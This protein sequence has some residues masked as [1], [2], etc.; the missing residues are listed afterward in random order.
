MIFKKKIHKMSLKN[1]ISTQYEAG[2][3]KFISVYKKL[4]LKYCSLKNRTIFLKRCLGGTEQSLNKIV[5]DQLRI[6][7]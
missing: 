7:I 1:C 2:L 5:L 4:N 3:Y 6:F